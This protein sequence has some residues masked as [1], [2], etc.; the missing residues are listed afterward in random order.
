MEWL[1]DAWPTR[2][3]MRVCITDGSRARYEDVAQRATFYVHAPHTGRLERLLG[4]AEGVQVEQGTVRD[5]FGNDLDVLAVSTAPNRLRRTVRAAD[6]WTGGDAEMFNADIDPVQEL[7]VRKGVFPLCSLEGGLRTSDDPWDIDVTL[8]PVGIMRVDPPEGWRWN[9]VDGMTVDG[10]SVDIAGLADAL[11]SADPDILIVP[12]GDEFLPAVSQEA[13]TAGIRLRL[14]RLPA[15]PRREEGRVLHSYGRPVFRAATWTL[16]GRVH[17]PGGFTFIESDLEGVV[18]LAGISQISIQRAS[19]TSPG[20]VISAM[21]VRQML[22]SGIPVPW[23]KN[24]PEGIKTFRELLI[25]D[26]GGFIYT[27]VPGIYRDVHELDFT[28]MYPS[29]MVAHNISPETLFAEGGRHDVVPELGYAIRTD[30]RGVIPA[31]LE[32]LIARREALKQRGDE[33][34]LKRADALKWLLVCCF[35]YTGYRNA[36]LGRIEAHEAINAYG[37]EYMLRASETAQNR[38]FRIVHGI[39]DSL[40]MTGDGDI[41]QVISD[42]NRSTGLNIKHEALFKWIVFLP[43]KSGLVGAL[44]RYYGLREDGTLK[45][46]G[47]ALRRR[48]VSPMAATAQGAALERM[49]DYVDGRRTLDHVLGPFCDARDRLLAGNVG[50]GELAV[51]RLVS[52]ERDEYL[53]ETHS[54]QALDLLSER[55]VDLH[56]GQYVRFIIGRSGDA[57]LPGDD[58]EYSV[59]H[60]SK[61]LADAAVEMLRPFADE[62]T[63]RGRIMSGVLE[64]PRGGGIVDTLFPNPDVVIT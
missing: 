16:R 21:Q 48:D 37:R 23:N 33:R 36:K 52:K 56:P 9:G 57:I 62:D 35:G 44:N 63:V 25:A 50:H 55:G 17:V 11:D 49:D 51:R 14:D 64:P 46:R 15:P 3:G 5:L 60:Y 30:V 18:E 19:R 32:P 12:E 6:F 2:E 28:A 31:V 41:G 8:P 58:G 7:F 45:V 38:G 13:E 34:S 53:R 1:L 27:P 42:I 20:T 26:R 54:S 10:E 29:I 4:E 59:W 43:V 39:V 61:L 24:T 40:W 47:I 22:T